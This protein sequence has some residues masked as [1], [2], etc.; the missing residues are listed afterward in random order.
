MGLSGRSPYAHFKRY[1]LKFTSN[2]GHASLLSVLMTRCDITIVQMNFK[3]RTVASGSLKC[4]TL[5]LNSVETLTNILSVVLCD[6]SRSPEIDRENT[7]A[8]SDM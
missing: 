3:G 7:I 2:T 6:R 5:S 1:A 4:A 8:R